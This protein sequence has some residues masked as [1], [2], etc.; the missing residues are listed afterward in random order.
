MMLQRRG[1]K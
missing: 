1:Q